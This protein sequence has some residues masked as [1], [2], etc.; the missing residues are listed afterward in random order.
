MIRLLALNATVLIFSLNAQLPASSELPSEV[1][2]EHNSVK[3]FEVAIDLA[4]ESVDRARSAY[5]SGDQKRAETELDLVSAL[6]D[7]CLHSAE[8][9]HKSKYWKK[10]EQ[11]IAALRRRLKSLT[12][13]LGYDQRDKAKEVSEHLDSI[14]DKL[15]SGVM[16]K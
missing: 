15:L 10:A 12:D 11:K 5:K 7:D 2:N 16:G 3:R 8:E 13:D 14:H 1:R 9:M 6:A 4:D